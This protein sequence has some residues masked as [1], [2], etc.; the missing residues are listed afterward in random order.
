MA[1]CSPRRASAASSINYRLSPTVK[2]PEHISDVADAFAWVVENLGK[3]GAGDNASSAATP[4][5][6]ASRPCWPPTSRTS[7]HK[8]SLG[9]IRG[10]IPISGVFDVSWDRMKD[11]FGDEASRKTASPM[12]FVKTGMPPFLVFYA[13]KEIAALGKQA[14]AF[15][16]AVK[17]VKGEIEVKMIKDRDHS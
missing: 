8:L 3:S 17:G 6:G 2:H 11:I 14:E 13:E 9:N 12:T 16:E 10:V 5:A 1:R 7:R 15:G 4:P